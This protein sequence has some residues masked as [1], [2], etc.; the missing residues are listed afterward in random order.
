LGHLIE[1]VGGAFDAAGNLLALL[2]QF[3]VDSYA[4]ANEE[5]M[6]NDESEQGEG[7]EF[8]QHGCGIITPSISHSLSETIPK[9]NLKP[10]S[11]ICER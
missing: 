7:L 8:F 6:C 5:T 10:P 9:P 2:R 11:S 3:S 1:K 4:S